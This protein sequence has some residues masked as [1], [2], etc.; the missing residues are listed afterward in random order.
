MYTRILVAL[1][2]IAAIAATAIRF[3]VM[4]EEPDFI[5]NWSDGDVIETYAYAVP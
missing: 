3:E 1:W 4:K 5:D 2:L